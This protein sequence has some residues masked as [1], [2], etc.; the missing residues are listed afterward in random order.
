LNDPKNYKAIMLSST[1]TDL[2]EHRQRAIE[3]IVKFGYVPRVM[4]FSGARADADVIDTSLQMV[5]DAAAYVGI[6]GL[7]YG[8]TPSDGSRNPDELSVTELEFNEAM[9]LGKPII[10]FI[11]SDKH[12]LTKADIDADSGQAEEARRVSRARE[13]DARR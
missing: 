12:K 7:K 10:L 2:R 11:M 1:F 4:E 3:A 5:R 6:I 9:R 8:Q 13:A